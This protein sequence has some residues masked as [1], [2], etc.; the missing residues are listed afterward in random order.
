ME[1]LHSVATLLVVPAG[2][3]ILVFAKSN[4]RSELIKEKKSEKREGNSWVNIRIKIKKKK[5]RFNIQIRKQFS[6]N[7]W[8]LIKLLITIALCLLNF[9]AH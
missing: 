7:K 6:I 8:D 5:V 9:A 1:L 2:I 3:A 4:N